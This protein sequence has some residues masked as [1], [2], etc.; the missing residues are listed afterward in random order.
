MKLQRIFLDTNVFIIGSAITGSPEASILEWL[1]FFD[2]QAGSPIVIVSDALLEQILRVGRRIGGKDYSGELIVRLWQ[3]LSVEHVTLEEQAWQLLGQED[4]IPRE[5]I[6]IFLTALI[7]GVECF[8]SAN[9]KLIKA[10]AA[11]DQL[12]E[13]LTPIEFV[14]KYID[15]QTY[16]H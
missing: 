14:T 9:H 5:D 11:T 13:C 3:N 15:S 6:P 16:G 4:V 7:G 2:R 10:L 8:I 12:F 1:G